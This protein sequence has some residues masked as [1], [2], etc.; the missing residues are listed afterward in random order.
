MIAASLALRSL[1]L[2]APNFNQIAVVVG[3][4]LR[5]T[6]PVLAAPNALCTV[7]ADLPVGAPVLSPGRLNWRPYA[8]HVSG[9]ANRPAFSASVQ[10]RNTAVAVHAD[11]NITASS[12]YNH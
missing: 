8:M 7:A 2:G 10:R 11:S 6:A 4:N 5:V 12:E 3:A 9:A 1:A